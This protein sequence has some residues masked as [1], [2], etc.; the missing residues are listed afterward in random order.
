MEQDPTVSSSERQALLQEIMNQIKIIKDH[1]KIFNSFV[2]S[3]CESLCAERGFMMLKVPELNDVKVCGTYNLS[4]EYIATTADIS[5]TIIGKVLD[6]GEAI[7]SV[8]AMKDPRFQDTTSVVISGLRSVLCVPV[9]LKRD[10]IG[11]LY[12][13]NKEIN[14]AFRS[15]HLHVL[16]KFLEITSPFIETLYARFKQDEMEK[17]M[18]KKKKKKPR[19]GI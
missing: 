4:P 13:D 1:N 2:S 6:E 16:Q 10:I 17:D 18:T 12:I 14:S 5:Q 7:V 15:Q 9:S 8:D 3:I 11:L 19:S